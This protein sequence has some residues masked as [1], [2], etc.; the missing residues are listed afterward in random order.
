M[1][2]DW[3][4]VDDL[5]RLERRDVQVRTDSIYQEIGVKSFG[6]GLFIKPPLRGAELGGKRVFEIRA[7]DFVVS[8]VFAWEGAVGVASKEHDRLIGSHRFMTW[9]PRGDV[10]VEYLRHYFG[11]E[12]GV[13]SLAAASPGSA[14]RNRTLSIKNFEQILVP[15]PPLHEQDRIADRLASLDAAINAVRSTKASLHSRLPV[16]L[17]GALRRTTR[18]TTLVRDLATNQQ[19]VVHPGDDLR[20]AT[21][22]VGLE[23]IETHTGRRT[24]SRPIGNETGRKLL[25]IPGQ[26]TYGYLRPYLNKAWAADRKGLCSVEQFTLAPNPGVDPR[27]L[28]VVLRSDSVWLAAQNATNSLQLPRLSLGALMSFEVADVRGLAWDSI[29]PAVERVTDMIVSEARLRSRRQHLHDSILPAAR[30]AVFD[31]MR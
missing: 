30:N 6:K 23:H 7:G 17:E 15:V 12:A 11:S 16:L 14:G 22:F 9:T 19:V 25:F 29:A 21:E 26:V 2:I 3:V 10:N 18:S 13:A 1:K 4:R 8:N 27:V 24:G 20:G 5:L 28:S 31:S